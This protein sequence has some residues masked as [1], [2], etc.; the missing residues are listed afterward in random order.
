MNEAQGNRNLP[1]PYVQEFYNVLD[2]HNTS[3]PGNAISRILGSVTTAMNK[4]HRLPRFLLVIIDK[5]VIE[6]INIFQSDAVA[7][8][9]DSI[10]WLTRQIH[11][12]IKRKRLELM[13]RKPGTIYGQDP[14]IIYVRMIRRIDLNL[15][16]NSVKDEQFALCAKFNDALN[17]AVARLNQHIM[18][19]AS[20][21]TSSHFTHLGE[22][23]TKGKDFF[24]WEIDDLLEKFN[25][26]DIKLLPNPPTGKS[27]YRR[28]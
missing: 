24:W 14:S 23:S 27:G 19:I 28:S 11:I 9:R 6:D 15:R 18:T 5:D 12:A 7:A 22:L 26:K 20:C 13:E 4:R 1:K 3:Q 21:N 17:N 8:L 25:R 2:Y 16:R 10:N